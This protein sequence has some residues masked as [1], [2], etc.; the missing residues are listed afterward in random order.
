[1]AEPNAEKLLSR[2]RECA[3]NSE[4]K[5]IRAQ[6][7]ARAILQ[8]IGSPSAAWPNFRG[9]LNQRLFHGAHFQIWSA[10]ELM[11]KGQ[12]R[13]EAQQA[14]LAGAEALE[15]LCEDAALASETRSEQLLKAAFAYYVAGHYA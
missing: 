3:Q 11:E 15:F 10:L 12:S 4:T 8:G 9:D 13:E 14:L 7:H 2:L 6:A 1:M 5:S